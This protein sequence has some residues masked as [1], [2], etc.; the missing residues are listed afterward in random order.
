M[1]RAAALLTLLLVAGCV[2]GAAP[3]QGA[4]ARASGGAEPARAILY[5]DTVTVEFTDGAL[6]VAPRPGRAARWQGVLAGCPH[7]RP[8]T[9]DLPAG[10]MAPR[11]VLVRL[12]G[13]GLAVLDLGAA[14]FGLRPGV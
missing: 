5:R 11:R 2:G 12:E 4:T 1:G 3:P 13:G 10:P 6:C 9:V 8:Y 14:Q 7:L